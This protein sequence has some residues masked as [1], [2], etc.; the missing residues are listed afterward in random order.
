MCKRG[1]FRKKRQIPFLKAVS[2][3]IHMHH[4][5]YNEAL[6]RDV[7][8]GK[9][10]WQLQK[11]KTEGEK[12]KKDAEVFAGVSWVPVS[13]DGV[14]N[15]LSGRSWSSSVQQVHVAFTQESSGPFWWAWNIPSRGLFLPL[16][17]FCED[18]RPGKELYLWWLQ[19]VQ[20]RFYFKWRVA[21]VITSSSLAFLLLASLHNQLCCFWETP[22]CSS[23]WNVRVLP[24][25]CVRRVGLHT[26]VA[27]AWNCA[28]WL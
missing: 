4:K 17:Y 21:T 23:E 10:S 15:N 18:L 5:V 12:K 24:Q 7:C 22:W 6:S 28:L 2:L 9:Q 14:E 1:L 16:L 26:L 8:S 20:L 11:A 13:N 19:F 27:Q 3:R 25:E